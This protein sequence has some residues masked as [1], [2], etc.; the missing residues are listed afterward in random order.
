MENISF[1]DYDKSFFV[2]FNSSEECN[3]FKIIFNGTTGNMCCKG[4]GIHIKT[5]DG[6]IVNNTKIYDIIKKQYKTK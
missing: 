1:I 6:K 2:H 3:K 5:Y 4:K